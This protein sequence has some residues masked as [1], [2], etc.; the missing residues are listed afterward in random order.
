[1]VECWLL[2]FDAIDCG[3]GNVKHQQFDN[4]QQ[5]VDDWGVIESVRDT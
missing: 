3:R 4:P 1:L 5:L 2:N